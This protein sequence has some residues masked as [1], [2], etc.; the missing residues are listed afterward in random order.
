[1]LVGTFKFR[2]E[3]EVVDVAGQDGAIFVFE[4]TGK[5]WSIFPPLL[6]QEREGVVFPDVS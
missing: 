2:L 5:L 3:F 4:N 6:A 1:M